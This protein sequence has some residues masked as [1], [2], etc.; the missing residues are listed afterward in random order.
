MSLW[1]RKWAAPAVFVFLLAYF[2]LGFSML[3]WEQGR[4]HWYQIFKEPKYFLIA[5]P[6][7]S[8]LSAHFLRI[9][10]PRSR[11]SIIVVIALLALSVRSAATI[12]RALSPALGD[13]KNAAKYLAGTDSPVYVDP[14][15][16]D[17]C[18]RREARTPL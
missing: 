12:H 11:L 7:V 13:V 6:V 16:M 8:L 3:R 15:G 1:Q 14:F 18:L 9:V 17:L 5:V 10:L 2:E 4:F